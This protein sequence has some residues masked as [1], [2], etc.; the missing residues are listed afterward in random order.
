MAPED[1]S[2]LVEH[3]DPALVRGLPVLLAGQRIQH[4]DAKFLDETFVN[5]GRDVQL[6]SPYDDLVTGVMYQ[7][8]EG[9]KRNFCKPKVDAKRP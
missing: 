4:V 2:A 6:E 1:A 9:G 7:G 3:E 8:A 5:V